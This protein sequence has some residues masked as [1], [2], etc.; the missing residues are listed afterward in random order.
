MPLTNRFIRDV[1]AQSRTAERATTQS[2]DE[3]IRIIAEY[4]LLPATSLLAW[5]KAY[6]SSLAFFPYVLLKW[7]YATALHGHDRLCRH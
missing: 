5:R 4:G 1:T 2:M 6:V 7:G 3:V